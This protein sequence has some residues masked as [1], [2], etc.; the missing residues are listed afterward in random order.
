MGFVTR[1]RRRGRETALLVAGLGAGLALLWAGA[2]VHESLASAGEVAVARLSAVVADTVVAE[3][4]RMLR[5]SE[6][7]VAPAGEVFRAEDGPALEPLVAAAD[8]RQ[9]AEPSVFETL[10]AEGERRER[11][12]DAAG[13]LEV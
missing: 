8:A 10:L 11:G 6:P 2:T 7:P 9:E 3:W 13:A 4:E 1:L 5:A 12:G